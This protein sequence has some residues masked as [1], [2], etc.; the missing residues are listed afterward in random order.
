MRRVERDVAIARRASVEESLTWTARLGAMA[1]CNDVDAL[2]VAFRNPEDES[3]GV[4]AALSEQRNP[5]MDS[6]D[7]GS[8]LLRANQPRL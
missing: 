2:R 3:S 4:G 8:Y 5:T 7:D 1:I 6:D